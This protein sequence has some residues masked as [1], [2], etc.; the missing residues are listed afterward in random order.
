MRHSLTWISDSVHGNW[1]LWGST[2]IIFIITENTNHFSVNR[3]KDQI[4]CVSNP[5]TFVRVISSSWT[6]SKYNSTLIFVVSLIQLLRMLSASKLLVIAAAFC[7]FSP[8]LVS[9]DVHVDTLVAELYGLDVIPRKLT[10][11]FLCTYFLFICSIFLCRCW[12]P[13]LC[14]ECHHLWRRRQPFCWN[15]VSY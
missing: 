5:L 1:L 7:C 15:N 14:H 8:H 12:L 11:V 2:G 13:C 10:L 4:T 3:D 6:V 9:V